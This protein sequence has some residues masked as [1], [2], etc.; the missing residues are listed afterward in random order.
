MTIPFEHYLT[1]NGGKL[2]VFEWPGK[3]P[4]LFFVHATGF[5]ARCWNQVI[6]QL[7]GHHC[8]AIDM[9]GHGRS[10]KPSP[11]YHWRSFAEDLAALGTMLNLDGAFGIGHSMGGH[12]LALATA[13]SPDLFAKLLLL[14][15]TILT[16]SLY[17]GRA[18]EQTHFA[19]RRRN[20]WSSAD[21]MYQRFKDRNPFARWNSAVLRDYCDYGLLPNENGEGLMLACPPIIE[22]AIYNHSTETDIYYQIATIKIPVQILCK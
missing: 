17:T 22:G 3:G 18:L 14:D 1:V 12:S 6:A 15:P 20:L 5:H 8:Y 16:K 10:H 19:T 9:R 2:A 4:P 11:P 7:S 13:L 21:E